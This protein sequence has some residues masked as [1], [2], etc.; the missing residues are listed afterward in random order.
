M[1]IL[2]LER[3]FYMVM[4]RW[5]TVGKSICYPH[6]LCTVE[7]PIIGSDGGMFLWGGGSRRGGN[8]GRGIPLT[9]TGSLGRWRDIST[10]QPKLHVLRLQVENNQTLSFLRVTLMYRQSMHKSKLSFREAAHIS[11]PMIYQR[12]SHVELVLTRIIW[13]KLQIQI[14]S[15]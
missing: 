1:G 10:R 15:A 8:G 9:G 7:F 4:N 3:W 5:Y 14:I 13:K 2:Y 11:R 6:L 12:Q